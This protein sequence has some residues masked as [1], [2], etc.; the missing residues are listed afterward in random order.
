LCAT[1]K[2]MSKEIVVIN[3]AICFYTPESYKELKRIAADKNEL[4]DTYADWLQGFNNA[5]IE[6]KKA[7]INAVPLNID[8][9]ELDQWC[10]KHKRKND[11]SA[12]AA[13][14]SQKAEEQSEGSG[15]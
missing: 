2:L 11:R 1:H 5:I 9:K 10:K 4:D 3:A 6:L 15:N 8:M 13:F 14:A 12:R 7:G